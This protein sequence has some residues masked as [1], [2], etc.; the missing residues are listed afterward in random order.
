MKQ[1]G[2]FPS[3]VE[4]VTKASRAEQ[5]DLIYV[6]AG[7]IIELADAGEIDLILEQPR[8]SP[9][10]KLAFI[11]KILDEIESPILRE[12]VE[13]NLKEASIKYYDSHTLIPFLKSVRDTIE[14]IEI[15]R[16]TV[17]CEFT[18]EDLAEMATVMAKRIGKPVAFDLTVD[19]S[20]IGGAVIQFGHY[21]SD[22]TIKTRLD[23]F[24]SQWRQAVVN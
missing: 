24:R 16:L 11:R 19:R 21:L 22:Y 18:P 4:I 10:Q 5:L 23:Q 2:P 17:A 15:V 14:G 1:A 3:P 7:S 12:A 20:I 8:K 9:T 13:R 6:S